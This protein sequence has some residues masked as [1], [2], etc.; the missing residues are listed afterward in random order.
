MSQHEGVLKSFF[1]PFSCLLDVPWALRSQ[2]FG[3]YEPPPEEEP[4]KKAGVAGQA[5]E[6]VADSIG[7]MVDDFKEKGAVGALKDAL[8]FCLMAQVAGRHHRRP[9]LGA[10]WR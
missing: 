3:N 8:G 1:G 6:F 10:R 9:R 5:A 4:T 2:G 7:D